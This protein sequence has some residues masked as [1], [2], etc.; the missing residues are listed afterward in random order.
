[1]SRCVECHQVVLSEKCTS[2]Q[3]CIRSVA[4][5]IH[6]TSYSAQ[7]AHQPE[8]SRLGRETKVIWFRVHRRNIL[9]ALR[10]RLIS[11]D[12]TFREISLGEPLQVLC[13]AIYVPDRIFKKTEAEYK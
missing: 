2:R 9:E 8:N 7:S 10:M 4:S 1:M 12:F 6:V 13:G 11:I 5:L 3:H